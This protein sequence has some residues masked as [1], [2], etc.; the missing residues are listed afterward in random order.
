MGMVEREEKTKRCRSKR[1]T[2]QKQRKAKRRKMLGFGGAAPKDTQTE[3]AW[4]SSLILEAAGRG[5]VAFEQYYRLQGICES[6]SDLTELIDSMCRP[7]PIA[8]RVCNVSF[9]REEANAIMREAND[10]L[11][12]FTPRKVKRQCIPSSI[13][14]HTI[15]VGRRV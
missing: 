1:A 12:N 11:E 9:R 13:P 14:P 5:K 8:F 2:V 3:D 7:L 4:D 6:E 10:L 15:P